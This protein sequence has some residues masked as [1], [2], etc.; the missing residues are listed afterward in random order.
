MFLLFLTN[1]NTSPDHVEGEKR[2]TNDRGAWSLD[3]AN[4]LQSVSVTER[5]SEGTTEAA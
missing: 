3:L 5:D 1:E 4:V 2:H